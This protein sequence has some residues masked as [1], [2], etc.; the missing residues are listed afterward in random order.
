MPYNSEVGLYNPD[1]STVGREYTPQNVTPEQMR[2]YR[3]QE[4]IKQGL[5]KRKNAEQPKTFAPELRQARENQIRQLIAANAPQNQIDMAGVNFVNNFGQDAFNQA[6]QSFQADRESA[7]AEQIA[8]ENRYNQEMKRREEQ[9]F[10][11]NEFARQ[12]RQRYGR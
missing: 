12:M 3:R 5:R 7:E 8:Q 2:E 6:K 11:D 1:G 10:F 9:H 4:L